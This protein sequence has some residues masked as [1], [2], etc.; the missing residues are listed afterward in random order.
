M[1][2]LLIP[3]AREPSNALQSVNWLFHGNTNTLASSFSF[4][5][6]SLKFQTDGSENK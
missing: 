2:K 1:H 3:L 4:R 5:N 6:K